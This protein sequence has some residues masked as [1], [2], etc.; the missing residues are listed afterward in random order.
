MATTASRATITYNLDVH[1]LSR[2]L[3]RFVGELV[4]S[5]SSGIS[6]TMPFDLIRVK[7][8]VS[9]LKSYS[10]HV[11]A[12]PLLDLPETSPDAITLPTP[13]AIPSMENDSVWDLCNLLDTARA[14]LE[15][16]QSSRL[17]TNLV[18]YDYQ[19]LLAVLAKA[20]SLIAYIEAAEPLDLPESAPR[21]AM[22]GQ[23]QLGV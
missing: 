16:S 7:T 21:D 2:R 5:Q 4:K 6:Q 23:G 18:K 11:V 13:T 1:S 14:E 3:N 20:E 9:A 19:R 22:T 10:G 8:F 15:N 12:D 17:S